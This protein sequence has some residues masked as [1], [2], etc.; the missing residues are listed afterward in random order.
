MLFVLMELINI[1]VNV[2]KDLMEFFVSKI[3]MNVVLGYVWIMFYV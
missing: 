2:L 1:F 3:L